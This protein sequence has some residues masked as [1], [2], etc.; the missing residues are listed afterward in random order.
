M[1]EIDIVEVPT[2]LVVGMRRRGTYAQLGEM[3]ATVWRFAA[4]SGAQIQGR[5]TFICHE[6]PK[7]AMKANEQ[8]NADVEVVVPVAKKVTRHGSRDVLR[9]ARRDHG[10]HPP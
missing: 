6:T 8:A 7:E 10:P 4:G 5:P 9:V 1:S 3:I 2:Q